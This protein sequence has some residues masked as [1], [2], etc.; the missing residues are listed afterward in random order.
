MVMSKNLFKLCLVFSF[1][2]IALGFVFAGHLV[3]NGPITYVNQSQDYLY[4]ISINNTET[5]GGANITAINITLP[6]GFTYLAG[7]A[8]CIQSNCSV[9]SSTNGAGLIVLNFLNGTSRVLINSS[10]NHTTFYFNATGAN[11]GFYNISVLSYNGSATNYS[12]ISYYV[13]A[14]PANISFLINGSYAGP[15]NSQFGTSV[16]VMGF[17]AHNDTTKVMNM[18]VNVSAYD[19][20]GINSFTISLWNAT[21]LSNN[22]VLI[23]SSNITGTPASGLRASAYITYINLTEGIYYLNVTSNDSQKMTNWTAGTRKIILDFTAPTVALISPDNATTSLETLNDTASVVFYYNVTDNFGI[24]NCSLIVNET[25]VSTASTGINYAGVTNSITYAASV[26]ANNWSV[27]CLDNASNNFT[28]L[29][30]TFSI[31]KTT[32]ATTTASSSSGGSTSDWYVTLYPTASELTAGYTQN[33]AAKYQVKAKVGVEFHSIGVISLT[34]S[35]ATITVAS[36]PQTN[37]FNIGDLKKFDVNSDGVYDLSVKLNSITNGKASVTVTS[38]SEVIPV[39]ATPGTTAP[40][41]TI[42]Q[43]P[44]TIGQEVKQLESNVWLWV[45]LVI[46][47]LAVIGL[48]IYFMKRN[49]TKKNGWEHLFKK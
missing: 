11:E 2:V 26:G 36:T 17:R 16:F 34:T 6:S 9:S 40:E 44:E 35:T 21:N 19:Q 13:N 37:T 3:N 27:I 48:I 38:I 24:V 42:N 5:N 47:I 22:N 23:N 14:P 39:V 4:N 25:V 18:T 46:V 28:T 10:L 45:G 49:N 8:Y 43:S 20:I 33:L 30:R 7:S 12:N 15:Y 29:S 41:T 1:I 32:A 31:K